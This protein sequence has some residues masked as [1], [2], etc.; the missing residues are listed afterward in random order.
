MSKRY[1]YKHG[2][3]RYIYEYTNNRYDRIAKDVFIDKDYQHA[4]LTN[5]TKLWSYLT[6]GLITL[7]EYMMHIAD[8]ENYTIDRM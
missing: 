8:I 1:F 2:M 5:I 6:H 3:D 7:D 4:M